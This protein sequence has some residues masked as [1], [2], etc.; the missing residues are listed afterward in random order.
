MSEYRIATFN[1]ENLFA[2]YKFK[3]KKDPMLAVRDGWLADERFFEINDEVDK[4]ITASTI[5][6]LKADVIALQEIE[7]LD[8]L[9][10]FRSKYLG[11]IKQY[12][13]AVAIDGND[14]RYIDVA[15]LSKYPIKNIHTHQHIREASNKAYLFSRDCL[16]ADIIFPGNKTVTLYINHFKSMMDGRD[17]TRPKRERQALQVKDII[18]NR[19]G[20]KAGDHPFIVLGDFNDYLE[21]DEQGSPAIEGLVKWAQVENVVARLPLDERWTHYYKKKK[22]Y[23]QLDYMLLSKC[24]AGKTRNAPEIERRG[25][26]LRAVKYEGKRFPGVG[27]DK[28]KASDHCPVVFSISI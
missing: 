6:A 15:L 19:F 17:E 23:K 2:R 26:P 14:P 21:T 22:A 10:R 11:G 9:K 25:L 16:E 20:S 5:K 28:P 1:A 8:T 7:N 3:K 24:L 4:K 13:Y 27:N 12:P 18:T